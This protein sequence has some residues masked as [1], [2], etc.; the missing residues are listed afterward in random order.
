MYYLRDIASLIIKENIMEN[1]INYRCQVWLN[2]E[3]GS[4]I[5]KLEE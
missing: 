1:K 3:L 5:E 2:I 4:D